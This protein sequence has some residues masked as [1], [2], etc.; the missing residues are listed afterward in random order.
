MA[1]IKQVA[2]ELLTPSHGDSIKHRKLSSLIPLL[3]FKKV[4]AM[5]AFIFML[6]LMILFGCSKEVDTITK[7]LNKNWKMTAWD[8]VTPLQGTPLQGQA[9]NWYSSVGC[10]SEMIWSFHPDG[11]LLIRDAPSCVAAGTTGIY[12]STWALANNN[13]EINI[14]GSPFGHFTYT[15]ISLTPS[16][17]VVQR[18]E[19]VGYGGSAVIKLV[20]Q[21][22]YTAQ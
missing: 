16:K 12:N 19:N 13:K 2:P 21:R 17:L 6:T 15:I 8:V 20:L 18:D 5:K 10:Y 11:S 14:D 1:R 4:R 9:T 3:T 22:E 7:L